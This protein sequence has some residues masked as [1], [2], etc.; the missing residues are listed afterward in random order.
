[1]NDEDH[2]VLFAGIFRGL[3]S[4]VHSQEIDLSYAGVNQCDLQRIQASVECRG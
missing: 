1:M 3:L 2:R 4:L